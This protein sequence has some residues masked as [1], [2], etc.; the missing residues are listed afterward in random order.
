MSL[1]NLL[2]CIENVS[3]PSFTKANHMCFMTSVMNGIESDDSKIKSSLRPSGLGFSNSFSHICSILITQL[4]NL[5]IVYKLGLVSR[6]AISIPDKLTHVAP[7]D[8]YS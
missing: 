5:V 6:L 1:F 8:P 3:Y 2:I 7:Y 4:M